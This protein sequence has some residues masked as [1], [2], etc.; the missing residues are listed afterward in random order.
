MSTIVRPLLAAM[1][2]GKLLHASYIYVYIW[3]FC[4]YRNVFFVTHTN[5]LGI[6]AYSSLNVDLEPGVL[7]SI[8]H[9][10][11]G[12][13]YRPSNM[14][15]GQSGAGN[16]WAKGFYTEG[17][18]L[19]DSVLDGVRQEVE[20]CDLL[21]GFQV[22]H[23]LGGGTGSGMGSLLVQKI[24]EE[25]PDRIMATFSVLPSP[26]VS[27]TVVE[28]YNAVLSVHHLVENS[29]ITFCFDNEALYD[30]SIKTL[31][32]DD[33]SYHDLNSLVARVMSGVTTS[34]RFLVSS[35]PISAS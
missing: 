11:Y 22:T 26:K 24:R 16:N 34:L 8:R 35:M 20:R 31:K 17:A 14:I 2:L 1:S 29:D 21:S 33:P 19:V 23:S 7:D 30:I 6:Y 9:S 27:D 25:Y 3:H 12:G 15:N 32:I 4:Q 28:P 5:I 13:L 10:K 18:E